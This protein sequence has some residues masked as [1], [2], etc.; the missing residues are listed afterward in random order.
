MQYVDGPDAH[1]F[2]TERGKLPIGDAMWILRDVAAALDYAHEQQLLHRDVKPANILLELDHNRRRAILSDFGIARAAGS[3]QLTGTGFAVGSSGY[4]SPEQL[5]ADPVDARSDVY[6]LGCTM[7]YLL[8]GSSP[9]PTDSLAKALLAHLNEPPPRLTDARPDLP[10]AVD[11]V[12]TR[13]LAKAPA[14]RFASAGDFFRALDQALRTPAPRAAPTAPSPALNP[15]GI[16]IRH[17]SR[18]DSTLHRPASTATPVPARASTPAPV[19][20]ATPALTSTPFAAPAPDR[21]SRPSVPLPKPAASPDI[22]VRRAEAPVPRRR[23]NAAPKVPLPSARKLPAAAE[24]PHWESTKA[25]VDIPAHLREPEV[26]DEPVG[27]NPSGLGIGFVVVLSIAIIIGA[28]A[29]IG[30]GRSLIALL[31]IG[32]ITLVIALV[33]SF[34]GKTDGTEW[35]F[36][37]DL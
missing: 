15:G 20:A 21:R 9:F 31:I 23:S 27:L 10:P 24:K 30:V 8:T 11:P 6:A 33:L 19:S 29:V 12:L 13:A 4:S 18:P 22:T 1:T 34:R 32:A 5:N 37:E 17:P 7:Y 28:V 35:E 14:D 36:H 2:T 25:R 26:T 3:T 16:T